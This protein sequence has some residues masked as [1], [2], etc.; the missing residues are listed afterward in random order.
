MTN[1]SSDLKMYCIVSEESLLR[2]KGI[3]GKMMAQSGHAF[4]HAFWDAEEHFPQT[5]VAYKNSGVAKKITLI[6]K[7]DEDL[8]LLFEK[9][10]SNMG[11]TFVVDAGLTVTKT[12]NLT[13]IGLGPASSEDFDEDVSGL[14]T[15][16]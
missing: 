14:K 12:P 4:L 11:A 10:Q 2:M 5:A 1:A 3:R 7:S 8:K 13:C 15:L 9:Y 6:T 16:T